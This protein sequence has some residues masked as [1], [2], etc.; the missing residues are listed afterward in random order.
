MKCLAQ[1]EAVCHVK[2]VL[3]AH[4]VPNLLRHGQWRHLVIVEMDAVVED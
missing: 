4:D 3:Y 2:V 1:I